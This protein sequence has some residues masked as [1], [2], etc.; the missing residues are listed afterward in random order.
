[1]RKARYLL[2]PVTE[3]V[4]GLGMTLL[5]VCREQRRLAYHAPWTALATNTH[6]YWMGVAAD[7]PRRGPLALS[8]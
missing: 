8:L 5:E 7:P 3:K 6:L 1:M 4:S 2:M